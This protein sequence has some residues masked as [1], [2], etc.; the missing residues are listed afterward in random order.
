MTYTLWVNTKLEWKS[1]TAI[2]ALAHKEIVQ[3]FPTVTAI[4]IGDNLGDV[5]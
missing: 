5:F 4:W 2:K 1:H 3:N